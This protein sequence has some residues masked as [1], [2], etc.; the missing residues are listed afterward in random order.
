MISVAAT[1]LPFLARNASNSLHL[2]KKLHSLRPTWSSPNYKYRVDSSLKS[3]GL[4][5]P[6]NAVW[7]ASSG[8]PKPLLPELLPLQATSC[9]YL[10]PASIFGSATSRCCQQRALVIYYHSQYCIRL[11]ILPP[12]PQYSGTSATTY[13]CR[14][15]K[16]SATKYSCSSPTSTT[17][18]RRTPQ[19]SLRQV[20]TFV[21]PA[22]D[23]ARSHRLQ[24]VSCILTVT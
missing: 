19:A 11:A 20:P 1:S 22:D 3:P 10:L 8:T 15:P 13:S 18:S 23:N 9:Y 5:P 2:R 6:F 21:R 16:S 14:C 17:L 7:C 24:L 4:V 12:A